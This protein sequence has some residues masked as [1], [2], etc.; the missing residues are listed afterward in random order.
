M[1]AV[2]EVRWDL[3]ATTAT[4]LH[5]E[6]AFVPSLDDLA[7]ARREFERLAAVPRC[8]ELFT[9]RERDADVVGRDVGS[10]LDLGAGA[11][12]LVNDLQLSRTSAPGKSISGFSR[13][14]SKFRCPNDMVILS[15]SG[16]LFWH[17]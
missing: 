3:E 10:T 9:R 16:T 8:V 6:Q 17:V 5:A 4:D 13:S 1:L 11:L 2:C 12:D 14:R 7:N 15:C